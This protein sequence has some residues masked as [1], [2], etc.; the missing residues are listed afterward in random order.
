M[1][2]DPDPY[3]RLMDPDPGGPKTCGS[4]SGSYT[5]APFRT[6]SESSFSLY[7]M[8]VFIACESCAGGGWGFDRFVYFKNC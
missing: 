3:I 1:D 7:S 8:H 4:G 2:P 5:K 6:L